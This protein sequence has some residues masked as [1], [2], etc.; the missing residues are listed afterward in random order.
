M[1]K[2]MYSQDDSQDDSQ[3]MQRFTP[4]TDVSGHAFLAYAVDQ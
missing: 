1:H 2:A 4:I 3:S